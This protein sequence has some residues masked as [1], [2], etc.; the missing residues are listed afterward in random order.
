MRQ[1]TFASL[2]LLLCLQACSDSH[3]VDAP[4]AAM[5]DAATP[6]AA[7]PDTATP[8][9]ATPDAGSGACVELCAMREEEGPMGFCAL[10]WN[11]ANGV[12]EERC[13]A[14]SVARPATQ[15]AFEQC[16]L[17]DPLCFQTLDDCIYRD[18]YPEPTALPASLVGI[19]FDEHE[20]RAVQA[21]LAVGADFVSQTGVVVD[22]RFELS[23][24]EV[25]SPS[26]APVVL[27]HVDVDGDGACDASVDLTASLFLERSGTFDAPALEAS[28]VGPPERAFERVCSRL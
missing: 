1:P 13:E 7:T 12:C 11:P 18:L 19:D 20:G 26:D 21:W 6:D 9:T 15:D 10:A 23:W 16:V 17:T 22:G 28:L 27:V 25:L 3:G 5:A 8:D 2:L 4:D 14:M 24:T